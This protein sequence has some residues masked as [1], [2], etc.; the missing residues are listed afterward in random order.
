MFVLISN[1]VTHMNKGFL[2]IYSNFYECSKVLRPKNLRTDST[3]M[4]ANWKV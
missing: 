4:P 3:S 2:G 1:I